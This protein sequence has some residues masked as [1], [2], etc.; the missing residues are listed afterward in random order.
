MS[1]QTDDTGETQVRG[2]LHH[3]VADVEPSH[4]PADLRGLERQHSRAHWLPLTLAAAM[5][6]VLALAGTAW[7][8]GRTGGPG[9][10]PTLT[11]EPSTVAVVAYAVTQ[12][13]DGPRLV[14][15]RR[16]VPALSSNL[17]SALVATLH[18]TPR[19]GDQRAWPDA[20][21]TDLDLAVE[22]D[23]VTI[24]L[25]GP[26][27]PPAEVPPLLYQALAWTVASAL[28]DEHLAVEIGFGGT[29]SSPLDDTVT[30]SASLDVLAPV[31]I[32]SVG[33]GELVDSPFT[34]AGRA[35][36]F[37]G[38]VTWQLLDSGE[39]VEEGF[40]TAE[41]CC[42]P[43]PYSFEVDAPPGPYVL[44]VAETDPSGGEGR[45]PYAEAVHLT[46]E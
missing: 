24:G 45:R 26:E 22:G 17:R 11:G 1:T 6:T 8:A 14:P 38:T 16:T 20:P 2:W 10:D 19:G 39:V 18:G 27:S 36:A 15:D 32:E 43:S 28:G 25:G 31:T 30:P 40:T 37:E 5:A 9:T 44:R 35:A 3:A 33:A 12:T 29:Q 13:L 42:V 46:V 4:G 34:V 21:E 7:V 23:L 41:E